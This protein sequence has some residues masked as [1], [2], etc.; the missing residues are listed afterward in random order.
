MSRISHWIYC[1]DLPDAV[2]LAALVTLTFRYLCLRFGGGRVWKAGICVLLLVWAGI[3]AWMTVLS[4][5]SDSGRQE[6]QWTPFYSY[7]LA[8]TGANREFLRSNF[9]NALLF[10]PA[11]LLAVTALPGKWKLWHKALLIVCVC[12]AL[13]LG[14]ELS[15]YFFRLGL[16]ETDDVL[17]NTLGALLGAAAGGIPQKRKSKG[18]SRNFD[19]RP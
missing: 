18:K 13:S 8:F 10:Y 15:Q 6:A 7:Y 12:C 9:M 2:L 14:I 5:A 17:H 11:G 16:A 4:R 19:R 1:L 3:A